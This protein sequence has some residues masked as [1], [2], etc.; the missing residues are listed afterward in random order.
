MI[1]SK[2]DTN[3]SVPPLYNNIYYC[4]YMSKKDDPSFNLNSI[5]WLI[6]TNRI[7][8]KRMEMIK[9]DSIT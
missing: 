2:P 3:P 4:K 6:N 5:Y 1:D 7:Y 8:D 9:F